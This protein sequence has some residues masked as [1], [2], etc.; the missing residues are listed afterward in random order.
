VAV[1]LYPLGDGREQFLDR[2]LLC[3]R[4]EHPGSVGLPLF[5][6]VVLGALLDLRKLSP[7]RHV[8]AKLLKMRE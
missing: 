5:P 4:L 2:R 7:N 3:G 8:D 6:Q 1:A